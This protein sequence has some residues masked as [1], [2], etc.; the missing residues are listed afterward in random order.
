MNGTYLLIILFLV[1]ILPNLL[2]WLLRN[3]TQARGKFGIGAFK[4][5]CPNCGKPQPIFRKPTSFKQMMFGGCTC[6]ACGTEIDK[7]GAHEAN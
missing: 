4:V 3:Q 6:R 1:V 5:E 7:Y 2:G